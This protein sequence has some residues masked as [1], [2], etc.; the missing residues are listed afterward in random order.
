MKK[1]KL[2]N[3]VWFY[4]LIFAIV[5]ICGIWFL[6]ILSLD[7]YYELSKKSEIK[8]IA[9]IVSK[10]YTSGDYS[11]QLNKLSFDK[12]VCIEITENNSIAYSTDSATRGCL[13]NSR[14]INNYKLEF[15][16]S[17]K[18]SI[19]YKVIHP[20]FKNKTLIY[21]VKIE[22]GTYAFIST[23]LEPIG[24]TVS[25]LKRQLIQIMIIVLLLALLI[26]NIISK[27][28]SKPME[29]INKASKEIS[30]G[31]YDVV[32]GSNS[33]ITEITE[34]EESLNEMAIE[35]SKTEELRRDLMANVSHDLK[36][37]LTLIKANAEMVKDLT[38]KNKEKR[39][40]NLNTII[41]EVDRLNLLVEDILDL[42]KIQSKS[43]ELNL[44]KFNLNGLIK[45]IINKFEILC[46]KDGYIINYEGFD[47]DITADK[48]KMQQTIYNLI[49]NAINYTGEDKK[50]YVKLFKIN[51]IVR[52]EIID[53]GNGIDE[54][55]IKYIWD[56]YYKVD[57]RYK[58]VTYGTG[59]G[60]SIVKDILKLHNF[61]YGVE[62][63]KGSGTK[64]YFD[65]KIK[66]I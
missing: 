28:I 24:S 46:E 32:F 34:L 31:N 42:S 61:N 3:K 39:E 63:K 9:T 35:L 51:D 15:M 7:L 12:D 30:K 19:T 22:D 13:I 18:K 60:L 58:R 54:K 59:L 17:D 8:D 56:K 21:G 55:D 50:V 36:T 47:I 52:V 41:E 38:Y 23:S 33:D 62:S 65:I 27:K 26:G 1:S 48:K 37:P 5:I 44:E 57:K 29:K 64:F 16:L 40:K 45:E 49:N 43:V 2:K 11:E 53:T 66:K 20:N 10:T 25:V 14:E 4:L 6:Q